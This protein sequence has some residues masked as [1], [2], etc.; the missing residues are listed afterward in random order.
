[1]TLIPLLLGCSFFIPVSVSDSNVYMYELMWQCK[2]CFQKCFSAIPLSSIFI[3]CVVLEMGLMLA[4]PLSYLANPA[5]R[6]LRPVFQKGIFFTDSKTW[7]N[8]LNY[9]NFSSLIEMSDSFSF[10]VIIVWLGALLPSCY[11]FSTCHIFSISV[12]LFFFFCID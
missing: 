1:M 12:F 9:F 8:L 11:F 3:I 6:L 2:I 4:I 10:S 7:S 5:L